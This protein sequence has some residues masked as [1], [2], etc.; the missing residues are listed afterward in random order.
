M[1]LES[2]EVILKTI[3]HHYTPFIVR[4]LKL[5]AATIP[6]YF[7][8]FILRGSLSFNQVFW[9]HIIIVLLFSLV[10]I[11]ITLVFWLDRLIITTRRIILIDWKYLTVKAEYEAELKEI[12]DITSIEKGIYSIIPALDY[13]TLEIKTSSNKTTIIFEEAPN[14]NGIKKIIQTILSHFPNND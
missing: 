8:I 4:I 6:F 3:Y 9:A 12:Q 7:L 2:G 1:H 10:T 11:Y 5:V 13:G 14:P